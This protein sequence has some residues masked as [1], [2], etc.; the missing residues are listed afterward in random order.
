MHPLIKEYSNDLDFKRAHIKY[1]DQALKGFNYKIVFF[2]DFFF[3]I[4]GFFKIMN[5]DNFWTTNLQ[6]WL[7]MNLSWGHVICH[8]KWVPD[9]SRIVLRLLDTND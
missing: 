4:G 8:K 5:I 7:P 2:A 1:R 6:M 3:Q 9:E